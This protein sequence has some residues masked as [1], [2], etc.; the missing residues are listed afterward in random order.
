MEQ[1]IL[2]E[3]NKMGTMPVVKLLLTMSLPMMF[4][5]LVQSLYNIVDSM[6]VSKIGMEA[7]TAVSLSFPLQMLMIAVGAGTGV[8]INA[9]LSKSLGEKKYKRANKAAVN[10]IFIILL[11]YVVFACIGLYYVI[12]YLVGRDQ[13]NLVT[14][15]KH[16]YLGI[17]I[18]LSIGVMMQMTMERLL[19][20]TGHT[21]FSMI[22]QMIGA[23]INIILD[24]LLIFG[25]LGFPKMGVA[26]AAL[27][28]VLG[29]VIA[30]SVGILFNIYGNKE[31]SISFEKFKPDGKI[32]AEIYRVGIPAILM[33]A[34]GS[35]T[36]SGINRILGG[37]GDTAVSVYGVYF[38]LQSFIFMPVFGLNNGMIPILAYN[39]GARSK[40]RI[41]QTIT[42]SV[43]FAI[44][45]MVLGFAIFQIMSPQ[46]LG[47]FA[48]SK[49]TL[50]ELLDIG[51]PALRTISFS[52]L[53]AGFCIVS[54]SVFQA[55]G[56]GFLSLI[57]SV[58][59][60][61][62]VILPAATILSKLYGLSAVWWAF[63]L[64]ELVSVTLSSL[65]LYR[66]YHKKIKNI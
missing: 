40:K 47:L 5:M 8:G 48:D 51:V 18:T 64:A 7:L 26:G 53:F 20:S 45:L 35:V 66:V 15:Y 58:C 28:T 31:I 29:Q 14:Q 50:K 22:S 32:I 36:T 46:L 49:K 43:T 38:K 60:Q 27:A 61:L 30:M 2:R 39:Y 21:M 34:I 59:R 11:S 33:Q 13:M 65:F 6:F 10:G 44:S 23:V 3:D 25:L 41:T 42:A 54:L 4:S 52:F 17:C 9:L 63:P 37:F 57:V 12:T 56:E 62:L 1:E 16:I 19:Q 24:P 55:F